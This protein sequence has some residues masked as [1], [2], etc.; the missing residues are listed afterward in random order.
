MRLFLSWSGERSQALG[1]A[2]KAWLPLVLQYAD[3]WLSERDIA[4]G[5]RWSLEVGQELESAKVGIICLT[6][7]NLNAP[8]VLFEAGA[9]SRVIAENAVCPYLLDVNV[10]D[11]TGPLTQ[12]QAK[13]VDKQGTLDLLTAINMRSTQPLDHGRLAQVFE[14]LWPAFETYLKVI[15]K[16][17][18]TQK[19]PRPQAEILEELVASVR[20]FDHRFI[21]LE[22]ILSDRMQDTHKP[23]DRVLG[24]F[25]VRVTGEGGLRRLN[26]KEGY[27]LV[28]SHPGLNFIHEIVVLARLGY[29]YRKSWFLIDVNQK[30]VLTPEEASRPLTYFGEREPWLV[31]SDEIPPY[32]TTW[33]TEGA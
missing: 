25:L 16:A 9:L 4:A 5:D 19:A 23:A 1:R 21:A 33:L 3:P 26:G 20:R 29:D 6:R 10:G 31:L 18:P 28:H 7:E 2:L 17:A 12:F 24:A 11:I 8:W 22:A 27:F 32:A 13:K 14:S 15:P 30:H